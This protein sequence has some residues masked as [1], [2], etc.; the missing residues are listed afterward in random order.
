MTSEQW[1]SEIRTSPGTSWTI[2]AVASNTTY[3]VQVR[4][5][6]NVGLNESWSASG[7]GRT[8]NAT[9]IDRSTMQFG[10]S[11]NDPSG[12]AWD[13]QKLYMVDDGT[14]ALYTLNTSTGEATRVRSAVRFGLSVADAHPRSLA[15]DGAN[16]YMLTPSNLYTLN[17]L[18]GVASLVGALGTTITDAAGLAWRRSR[19]NQTKGRLYMVDRATDA[20]YILDTAEGSARRGRATRVDSSTTQFGLSIDTPSGL[21]WVGSDLY[22]TTPGALPFYSG[23]LY[24]LRKTTGAATSSGRLGVNAP[25]DLAWDGSTMYLVDDVTDALYTVAGIQDQLLG[26][27]SG[28]PSHSPNEGDIYYNGGNFVD[29]FLRWDNPSWLHDD[30][31]GSQCATDVTKCSTYEHHLILEWSNGG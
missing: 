7:T 11:L 20:L 17:K 28:Q 1:S 27:I 8:G 21:V 3:E 25:T 2:S 19:L 18:T 13:G 5:K 10:L 12:I 30:T 9:R 31:P 22:T 6:N 23:M 16:L 4:A 29:V 15:W 24:S 14:D 26:S